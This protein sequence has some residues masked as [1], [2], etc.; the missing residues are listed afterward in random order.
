MS[1]S[2]QLHALSAAEVGRRTA[3]GDLLVEDYAR[4]ILA[5]IDTTEPSLRAWVVYDPAQVLASARALDALPPHK[6]GP[7]HGVADIFLTQE[8]PTAYGSHWAGHRAQAGV[9]ATAVA[10]LRGAGALIVGKTTTTQFAA[11]THGPATVNAVD[12]S[13]TPG[14]SSSGSAAAVA[15][16]Q[17]P[18]ALGTQTGGSI[19]RPASF[20]GVWGFKPTWNAISR[21]GVK[22]C[23]AWN[24]L[25]CDTVGLFARSA[26]DIA[27]ASS[28][29]GLSDPAPAPDAS[30]LRLAFVKT[31]AWGNAS[32]ATVAAFT[33]ARAAL[34]AA[35]ARVEDV[36]LESFGD[37]NTQ[38]HDTERYRAVIHPEG[39][40]AFLPD[41]ETYPVS[42]RATER[43]K[44]LESDVVEQIEDGLRRTNDE[45][46]AALDT[47]ARLRPRLDKILEGYDAIITPSTT[48]VAP[49]LNDTRHTGNSVFCTMW[50][51]LHVPVVNVP[52]ITEDR[53]PVGVSVVGRRYG[54]AQLLQ[55][56]AAVG[57]VIAKA[58]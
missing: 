21:D 2:E 9:D 39:A 6:R 19:I 45:H 20:N 37:N 43:A 3:A 4:A 49:P 27:L 31:G 17:V 18:L 38:W 50:T 5:H 30:T 24:S 42:S 35:G 41:Y 52:C 13:R 36:E 1:N 47:Y 28:V 58:A 34:L 16:Y 22:I 15:A 56:A 10:V 44:R 54:D 8:Y 48:G 57:Q 14:G 26:E 40:R 29:F 32:E 46:L 7:L 25:T 51:V 23:A 53:L 11:S 12:A 33:R 55:V